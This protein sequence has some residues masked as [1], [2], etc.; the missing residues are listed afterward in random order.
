MIGFSTIRSAMSTKIDTLAGFKLSR[1]PP[2]MIGRGPAPISHL[3][4]SIG[5]DTISGRGG[6]QIP[7]KSVELSTGVTVV[8]AYRLKPTSIYP[9]SYDLAMTQ[10][11]NLILKILES[12]AGITTGLEIEFVSSSRELV[13]SAEYSLHRLIFNIT[14]SINN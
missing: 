7:S 9:S 2:D 1:F 11:Q 5:F 3:S 6:R 8:F 13:E 12:Y 4:Y 14:H 10:E